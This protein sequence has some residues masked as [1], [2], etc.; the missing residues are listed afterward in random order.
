MGKIGVVGDD[1]YDA[2]VANGNIVVIFGSP[3]CPHCRVL[4]ATVEQL[5]DYFQDVVF[6]KYDTSRSFAVLSRFGVRYIPQVFYYKGG[7]K[8]AAARP[9]NMTSDQLIL[10]L[11]SVYR[12]HTVVKEQ[13]RLV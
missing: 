9:G 4:E 12:V 8:Y 5:M 6:V 10:A 2:T 13:A 11:N 1:S 7:Q 3:N